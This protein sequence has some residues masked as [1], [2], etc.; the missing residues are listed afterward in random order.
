[1]AATKVQKAPNRQSNISAPPPPRSPPPESVVNGKK[2]KKKKGKPRGLDPNLP[3]HPAFADDD[4]DDVPQLEPVASHHSVHRT[5]LS[6]E[7]E[8]VHLSTTASLSASAA[9]AARLNAT[10]AAQAEL[11]ATANDLYRRMD[12]DSMPDDDDYWASLP[13]HIKNF[14]KMTYSQSTNPNVNQNERTKAQSMF[15]IAQQMIQSGAGR[16][17]PKGGQGQPPGAYPSTLPFDPSIFSDPAFNLAMEQT[18]AASGPLPPAP[19]QP[20]RGPLPPTNVVLLNEFGSEDHQ[21]MDDDYYSEDEVDDNVDD[22]D[23][24]PAFAG[25]EF[26]PATKKKSKKKKKKGA[27]NPPPAVVP[28]TLAPNPPTPLPAPTHPMPASRPP[29]AA[30][31]HPAPLTS[32]RAAGKQP[33]SYTAPAPAA[34]PPPSR[35]SRAASKAPLPAHAYSHAHHHPSPPS[36]QTSNKTRPPAAPPKNNKLWSTNSTEERER[37]KEFWLGLGE[38]ERRALVKV[39]KE[40]VLKKMKEQQKHSCSCAVCGRKRYVTSR[41]YFM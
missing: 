25:Y 3:S 19:G 38:E 32:S 17:S 40:A 29:P 21:P 31:T 23:D 36:S 18:L 39:E 7:L 35:T 12:T 26:G 41:L 22:P 8:S 9:A 13:S 1:M 11:L 5:G 37:I 27:P 16:T 10:A 2:K 20:P 14:V 30:A 28:P 34:A 15:A 24:T 6:P 33:M 4:D